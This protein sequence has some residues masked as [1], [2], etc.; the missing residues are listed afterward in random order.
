MIDA[1]HRASEHM[2]QVVCQGA[3]PGSDVEHPG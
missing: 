1:D 3:R 2:G